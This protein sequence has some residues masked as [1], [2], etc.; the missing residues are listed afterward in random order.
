MEDDQLAELVRKERFDVIIHSA[1]ERRPDKAEKEPE[2]LR[3]LNVDTTRRI[4]ELAKETGAFLILISTDAVFDG[5]NP[6]FK[7]DSPKNPL[8]LYG[9]SKSDSEDVSNTS[10]EKRVV[11]RIPL[12]YGEVEYLD[13]ASVSQVM[14]LILETKKRVAERPTV[15]VDNVTKR[16]PTNVNDVANVL[17]LL[18]QKHLENPELVEGKIFH[19]SSSQMFTKYALALMMVDALKQNDKET[20]AIWEEVKSC[21]KP[22]NELPND[23]VLR[24]INPKLD[25]SALMKLLNKSD[26]WKD[27]REEI[28]VLVLQ[29]HRL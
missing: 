12:L 27:T 1:A 4:S 2:H 20:T 23:G 22:Q 17:F 7:E 5:A 29:W 24:P 6:P 11:L 14:K 8:N 15:N 26:L 3:K 28:S 19:C 9:V 10:Y 13:E 16:H 18:V 25:S 21:F